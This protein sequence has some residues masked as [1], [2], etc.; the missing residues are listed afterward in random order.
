MKQTKITLKYNISFTRAMEISVALSE[1]KLNESLCSKE[2]TEMII[3]KL[4]ITEENEKQ[5]I[6]E[7][8]KEAVLNQKKN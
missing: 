2:M 4:N 5:A 3:R 6:E 8:V 7:L 1:I